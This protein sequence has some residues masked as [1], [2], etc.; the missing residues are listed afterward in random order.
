MRLAP[1][2]FKFCRAAFG[3]GGGVSEGAGWHS[4]STAMECFPIKS[5]GPVQVIVGVKMTPR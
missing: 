5:Y 4:S 3:A 1:P 2:P